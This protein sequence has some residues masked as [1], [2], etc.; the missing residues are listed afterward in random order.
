MPIHYCFLTGAYHRDDAL[1]YYRQGRSLAAAGY[2]VSYV[3]CDG[4]PDENKDGIFMTSTDFTPAN[5]V[6]KFLKTGKKVL[7]KALEMDADIYQISDPGLV[8]I[9]KPLK[10]KGKKV[11]FNVRELYDMSIRHKYYIPKF[12]RPVIANYFNQRIVS[13][14]K[15]CNA[16]FAVD[17]SII[18]FYA[19]H[20]ISN[21]HLLTNFPRVHQD[22]QLSLQDYLKRGNV[23]C[24]EGT[25]Y[26]DSRQEKFFDA[27]EKLPDIKYLMAGVIEDKND[28]IMDHG[29]WHKV[30][31]LG[32]FTPSDLP[33]IF[34]RA[35]MC[36]V[37]RDL[38]GMDGSL[39]ILKIYESMEAALPVILPD[40][41]MYK[42]M[43]EKYPCG[44]CVN[45]NDKQAIYDALLF[46]STHK[47]KA[48]QMGQ[49]GRRA[50]LEEYNWDHEFEKYKA[51]IED[52]AK[53]NQ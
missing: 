36:H 13:A 21:V 12:L 38:H 19:K 44:I 6:D 9:V 26:K 39:G 33:S 45:P 46:L 5:R 32:K 35:S 41:P 28:G 10:R 47:E 40:A 16:V 49:E 18:D 7:K 22:Y 43:L 51:I 25:I 34:G 30:E 53:D 37:T 4:L 2:R 20:N 11:I 3:L 27:L 8:G 48:Y 24:Y 42:K 17:Y 23:L 15:K 52:V 14:L 1:M 29:Y 50:V 31:F